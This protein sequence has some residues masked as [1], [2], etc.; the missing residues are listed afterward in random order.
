MSPDTAKLAACCV[1]ACA[2]S[3]AYQDGTSHAIPSEKQL[4]IETLEDLRTRLTFLRYDR[5]FSS[6]V[7]KALDNIVWLRAEAISWRPQRS[8]R[9]KPPSGPK[10]GEKPE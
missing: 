8:M 10:A 3:F 9:V 4:V 6:A 1:V 5:R 2:F 7:P